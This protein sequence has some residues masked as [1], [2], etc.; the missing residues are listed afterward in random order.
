MT[1]LLRIVAVASIAWYL[2][3]TINGA[4]VHVAAFLATLRP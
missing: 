3:H 2:G 4:Y 1:Y